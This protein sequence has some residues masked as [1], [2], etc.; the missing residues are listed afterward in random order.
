MSTELDKG[1]NPLKAL[2][3]AGQSVWLDFIQRSLITNGELQR[4]I[5]KDGVA[6]VTSNPAIFEKA[7]AGSEDYSTSIQ[8]L[9]EKKMEP[10]AVYEHLAIQDIQEAADLFRGL[11][12]DTKKRDGYVSLEVSPHLAG[13]TEGTL[14]E[15]RRLWRAVNRPNVLIKV[16]GTV[17]GLPA[18]QTLIREGINVNITLLFSQARYL[19]VVEAYLKGLEARAADGADLSHVASVASF[20][21]QLPAVRI[22][23]PPYNNWLKKRWS[24]KQSMNIWPSKTSRK[25]RTCS[26][27][28]TMTPRKGMGMSAW[29]CPPI[30]PGIRKGLLTKL[31][32]SG[33]RSIVQTS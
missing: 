4:L 25:L 18:I 8:Q 2:R 1:T 16:P 33:V 15:A 3:A 11:Y 7:I 19:T 27:A 26:V 14:D 5:E 24:Q 9:A 30:W 13:N 31:G 20:F 29:R 12:D 28:C 6:G 21:S 23:P 17:E 22:I 32:A 10:K